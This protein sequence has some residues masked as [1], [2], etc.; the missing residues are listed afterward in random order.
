LQT[1]HSTVIKNYS[2]NKGRNQT[3]DP[4]SFRK[5]HNSFML[6][7]L[8]AAEYCEFLMPCNCKLTKTDRA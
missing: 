2:E 4:A 3:G 1:L 5:G 7:F 8:G 6:L